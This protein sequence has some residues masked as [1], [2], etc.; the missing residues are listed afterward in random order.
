MQRFLPLLL[1]ALMLALLATVR[2]AA[3]QDLAATLSGLTDSDPKPAIAALAQSSDDKA[4]AAL[5]ALA[6]GNLYLRLSDNAVVIGEKDGEML[7]ITNAATGDVEDMLK[8]DEV[9]AI[10]VPEEAKSLLA[11]AAPA[12]SSGP[13]DFATALDG[14]TSDGFADKGKA[15]DAMAALGDARAIPVFRALA[16]GRLFLR[17]SDG[18][19][20]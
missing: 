11:G 7:V 5:A 18:Q 15:I 19:L 20:V 2:P 3:A 4:K 9:Q 10:A 12:A 8:P 13:V 1:V 6:A 17:K 16:D 14:L